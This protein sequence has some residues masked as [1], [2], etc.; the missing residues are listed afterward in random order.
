VNGTAELNVL[1]NELFGVLRRRDGK[2]RT[3]RS[4]DIGQWRSR[5]VLYAAARPRRR[6]SC[7]LV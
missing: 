1:I 6:M 5:A 7:M 4:A 3:N 2:S